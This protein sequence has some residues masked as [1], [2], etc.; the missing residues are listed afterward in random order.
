MYKSM[1]E[2]INEYTNTI[3]QYKE[4]SVRV[5]EEINRLK[6][7]NSYRQKL[8]RKYYCM[9]DSIADMSEAVYNMK[10]YLRK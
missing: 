6:K 7:T 4:E 8:I 9:Q 1:E 10:Q 2:L 5:R 3:D